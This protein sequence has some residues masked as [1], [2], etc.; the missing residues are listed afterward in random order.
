MTPENERLGVLVEDL[1]VVTQ[2]LVTDIPARTE[3][4]KQLCALAANC[5][6][7]SGELYQILRRLKVGDNKSKWEGLMV[8]WHSMRKE[9]EI[10]SIEQRL[11]GYRSQIL[12]RL[13]A[14]FSQKTD[15]QN[16]LV[17]YQLETLRS[18][19]KALQNQTAFQLDELHQTILTLVDSL[20]SAPAQGKSDGSKEGQLT[21]LGTSLFEFQTMTSSISRENEILKSLAFASVYSRE[22]NI[23][24]AESGTFAWMVDEESQPAADRSDSCLE[25]EESEKKYDEGRSKRGS[26]A[27]ETKKQ[28]ALRKCTREKFLTW[29]NSGRH[30]F[31]ISGKAGSGKSTLM[32]FLVK[33]SRVKKEL[34]S[35]AGGRPLIFAQFFFWNA[36]DETQRNAFSRLIKEASSSGSYFCFFIDGLDE[37]EGDNIDHWNLSQ[38]LQSWTAKAENIKLCVSSRPHIPFVQSFANGLNHHVSI[39]EL[40]REDISKFSVAMFEKDPNFHRIKD[41][42]ED[43]VI[44]IVNASDGVFL[45]A[46]LVVRSLLKSI[47]YQGSE[48]DL[49]R[50]LHLMPKGLDELFDQILSS[51]DPDDQ[52]LSDQLFL[53]TTPNFCRWQPIVRNAI[54]YSWLEGLEDSS[55]P[56]E[57]PMR[58]CTVSEIDERL[59]RVSCTLDCLSQ[60]LLEM[61]RKR[62]REIDGHDYFT[63]EVQFLHRSARDYIVNTREAQMRARNPDFDVCSGIIRLLLAEFKFALP[64]LHDTKPRVW[65]IGIEGG[66][67]R[68]A[69][70]VLFTVMCAAHEHCGYDVPSRF[71]E[72]ASH[73][74][75][76]HAQTVESRTEVLPRNEIPE[77]KCHIWGQNL[78]RIDFQWRS[79]R[80]SNHSPDFLCEV[81]YRDLHQLLSPDLM[82]HLKQQNSA[83]GPNVLLTAA[84][85]SKNFEFVQELLHEG[86]TPKEMVPMETIRPLGRRNFESSTEIPAPQATVSV[87][88]IFLYCFIEDYF[89]ARCTSDQENRCLEEFLQYDVDR[90]VLFVVR[91]LAS[92][93]EPNELTD[94]DLAPKENSEESDERVAFELLEFL[95]LVEP[96]NLE[97]LRMRLSSKGAREDPLEVTPISGPPIP[98][99]RGSLSKTLEAIVAAGNIDRHVGFGLRLCLESVITPSERLD[100]PFGFRIT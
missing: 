88:S 50:K 57:L 60:G 76:H 78:Q 94:D 66:P 68:I 30:I 74:V 63:Y 80:G 36:G 14:M 64:T 17:N 20:Q 6:A 45:W 97:I 26:Y 24:N 47:G 35:W 87:W 46:R 53:L 27:E 69:L 51:I 21:T 16:C 37:F 2:N 18:E 71:F 11:N 7:L 40:T 100:V 89:L 41:S 90:D 52:L 75:Q 65:V 15:V 91:I 1:N 10:D 29:L 49:K 44:E 28:E 83:S 73:I 85:G 12:I 54:A 93:D 8:K 96:S 61:T 42:Y 48:K 95:E 4:E 84:T 82:S 56:Y 72:E 23:E 70:H 58:P 79:L 33:S 98:Y 13:Q 9:K 43:L 34:E 25:S 39:H 86:R 19:S 22:N 38:N 92:S 3:N 99:Q 62:S 32:K 67:L 31:H 5:H 77:P 55:F 59:E 81:V